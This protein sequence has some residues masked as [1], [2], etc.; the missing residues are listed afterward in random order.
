[1]DE[2]EAELQRTARLMTAQALDRL[3]WAADI[4]RGPE[5]APS[6]ETMRIEITLSR[7]IDLL[8]T[9]PEP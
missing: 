2:T 5:V 9:I 7:A 6:P 8:E 3:R 1:M 4:L